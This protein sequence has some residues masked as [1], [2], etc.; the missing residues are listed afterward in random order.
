MSIKNKIKVGDN[1][2]KKNQ[3]WWL[4]HGFQK[5]HKK[6]EFG[7]THINNGLC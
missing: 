5:A 6:R 3:H 1:N 4:C 2:N 7:C